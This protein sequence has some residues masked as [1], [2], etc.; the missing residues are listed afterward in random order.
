MH[1]TSSTPGGFLFKG[2]TSLSKG[3]RIIERFSE[4]IDILVVPLAGASNR[5][6]E[7]HLRAITGAVAAY[8]GLPWEEARAPGRGRNASRGDYIRYEPRIHA[9]LR[10]GIGSGAV[11]LETGYSAGHEPA[12]MVR[13]TPLLCEPLGIDPNSYED[14]QPFDLRALEP[15]RTLIEKLFALHH[16][17]T[18]WTQGDVRD[19]DRF[20][21]H[22][23]DVYRLLE[24][25]QTV[26][27]LHQ[28]REDFGQLVA[29]VERLSD[30]HFG[31]TTPRPQAGF[32]ASPACS[33]DRGS[34][35]R[36]W[37]EA[38]FKEGLDLLPRQAAAPSFGQVVQRV[39]QF[40][41]D[42]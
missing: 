19:Q 33:P 39:N 40:S 15:I 31:G 27:R 9:P 14:T 42:L 1:S 24:H 12:E 34:E 30:L 41:G 35:L 23:Y 13:T 26:R 32:A 3:Y 4:D 7:A 8:L 37:L 29:E 2:G 11:L 28:D 10:I 6:R 16:I 22:Y 38:K 21:R 18:L 5:Q 36:R 20:G 17:A 25:P